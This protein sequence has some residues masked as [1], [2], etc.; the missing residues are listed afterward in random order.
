MQDDGY[1]PPMTPEDLA[2][3]M[4]F[5]GP[6]YQESR[7]IESF[8]SDNPIPNTYDSNYGSRAIKTGLERAQHLAQ[9]SLHQRQMQQMYVAP[10]PPV[11]TQPVHQQIPTPY[12]PPE[13]VI[14]PAPMPS[15]G[16]MEFN[17][18][19]ATQDVTNDL[20]KEISKKLTTIIN[21]LEKE[22][23]TD[24]IPKSKPKANVKNQV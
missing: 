3:V 12:T 17:F 4:N 21:L 6:L 24:T 16:Q 9:A 11:Y 2:V 7:L 18:N 19:P 5:A 14:H 1:I 10:A 23:G 22:E 15:G 8:T 13:Q 20:L